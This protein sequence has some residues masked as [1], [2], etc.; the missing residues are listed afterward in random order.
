MKNLEYHNIF[1]FSIFIYYFNILYKMN[2][3]SN[4]HLNETNILS[5]DFLIKNYKQILL[6]ILVFVIVF[7]VEYITYINAVFYNIVTKPV[8]PG[9]SNVSAPPITQKNKRKKTK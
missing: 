4:E 5:I 2:N 9:V 8:I 7:M 1:L 6:L 3:N